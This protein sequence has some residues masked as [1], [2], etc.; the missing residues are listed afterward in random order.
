MNKFT[1][2][3][4][5][6][7]ISGFGGGYEKAC[8]NM[9]IAGMKWLDKNP[10]A[11]IEFSSYQNIYG[12]VTDLS[13]DC[14]KMRE[15]MLKVNDGCSGAQMQASLNHI[16]YAHKNGWKNYIKESEKR[17]KEEKTKTTKK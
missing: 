6:S 7:E 10:K 2:T 8:R 17:R 11:K 9:V 14:K 4:K 3:K 16:M 13:S 5:C 12:V 1:Y 15:A